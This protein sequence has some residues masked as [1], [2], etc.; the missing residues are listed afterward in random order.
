MRPRPEYAYIGRKWCGCIVGCATDFGDKYTARW[1]SD[2]VKEGLT[3]ERVKLED[4]HLDI[5]CPHGDVPNQP[6]LLTW[7]EGAQ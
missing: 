7:K 1:L 5:D 3:V 6:L 4:V 2:F